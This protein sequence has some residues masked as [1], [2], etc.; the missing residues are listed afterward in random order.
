M[1]MFGMEEPANKTNEER[2]K[3][4]TEAF[5]ELIRKKLGVDVK[6]DD[7]QTIFRLRKKEKIGE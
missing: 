2:K 3:Q 5:K 1:V 4:D 7:I 6:N